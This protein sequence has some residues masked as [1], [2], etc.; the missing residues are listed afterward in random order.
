MLAGF[1]EAALADPAT[2]ELVIVLDGPDED[3]HSRCQ[4]LARREPRVI[5]VPI[6]HCGQFGALEVGVHRA[7]SEV[8]L[9][10][11]DDVVFGP[12]LVTGH[13]RHHA[14][15]NGIVVLGSMPVATPHGHVGT[16]LYGREYDAHCESLVRGQRTVLEGLWGGNFSVRRSDCLRVGVRSDDFPVHYHADQDFGLRLADAGLEGV[17]DPALGALHRHGCDDERFLRTAR[18]QGASLVVLHRVHADRLGPFDP[19]QLVADLPLPVRMA[20]VAVG[21]SG[22]AT[23][24]ARALLA[25]ATRLG[26]LVSP[27]VEIVLAKLARRIMMWHGT[28]AGQGPPPPVTAPAAVRAEVPA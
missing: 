22:W 9:M 4:A 18:Q 26:A 23:T 11:D 16:V 5:P 2:S 27:R 25:V 24:G 20:V 14:H 12:S 21:G 7:T 1:V 19:Y 8:I 10:A 6:E 28:V 17:Y 13:A 3:V 15:R